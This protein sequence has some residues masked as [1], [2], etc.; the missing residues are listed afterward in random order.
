MAERG[1]TN[2]TTSPHQVVFAAEHL[3][4]SMVIVHEVALP[5]VAALIKPVA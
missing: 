1:E 3:Q 4:M 5:A 2:Q